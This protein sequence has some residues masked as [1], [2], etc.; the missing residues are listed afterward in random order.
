MRESGL[1]IGDSRLGDSGILPVSRV[2]FG[3]WRGFWR[4]RSRGFVG[5]L[6]ETVFVALVLRG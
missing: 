5:A 6:L 2:S 1:G 3:G 4:L